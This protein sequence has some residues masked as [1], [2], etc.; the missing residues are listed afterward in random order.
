V[1]I[2]YDID[3]AYVNI[4]CFKIIDSY[5]DRIV[6]GLDSNRNLVYDGDYNYGSNNEFA[7]Y[8][9]QNKSPSFNTEQQARDYL[10]L[11]I[12]NVIKNNQSPNFDYGSAPNELYRFRGL[13]IKK[14]EGTLNS[15]YDT[16]HCDANL[17]SDFYDMELN[18]YLGLDIAGPLK[19]SPHANSTESH[20]LIF[21]FDLVPAFD[22][23][24]IHQADK[25]TS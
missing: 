5:T 9:Q 13:Q 24:S 18:G 22:S 3:M 14:F 23:R 4:Q 8:G 1:E 17:S 16:Y 25:K 15:T 19:Y 12:I 6:C 10:Q 2:I 11:K 7:D 20:V 21:C